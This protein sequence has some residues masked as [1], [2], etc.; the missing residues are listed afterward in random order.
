MEN[1]AAGILVTTDWRI[2]FV[3][4]VKSGFFGGKELRTEQFPYSDITSIEPVR[5]S[6]WD[7]P[8]VAVYY[9]GTRTEFKVGVGED[10]FPFVEYSRQWMAYWKANFQTAS[11]NVG[12]TPG[13]ENPGENSPPLSSI[14]DELQKLANL[15]DSGVL[16]DQEFEAQKQRLL[17]G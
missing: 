11:V 13:Q 14:A 4:I 2:L 12:P 3:Y 16:T 7:L 17:G 9:H 5:G 6:L 1:T 8:K 10:K 15:R